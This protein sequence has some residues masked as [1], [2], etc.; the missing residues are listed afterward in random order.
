MKREDSQGGGRRG[1]RFARY[2]SPIGLYAAAVLAAA[3]CAI[4]QVPSRTVYEDPVNFVR[5]ELDAN[6]LPEWPPGH[7][8]HPV[9]FSPEQIRRVLMGLT[10]QEHRTALQR[11]LGGEPRRVPMFRD[12]E[13]AILVPQLVEA[14]RLAKENERVTYY[15][16]QPQTSIKRII[17]SGGLYVRGTELHFILGNWQTLYGIPAYGMIYDRRYPM[18]PIISK[19]FDLFFDLD[20]ARVQQTTSIWDSLLAN[21]KDELVIDLA[22]V[23]PGQPV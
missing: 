1:R 5:L 21:T 13:I 2:V 15:L 10:V 19:G 16:S 4:P 7:F 22:I 8:T 9:Q 20:Q 3:G 23:F 14:L 18:N 11:W 6:V 17:T 12:A